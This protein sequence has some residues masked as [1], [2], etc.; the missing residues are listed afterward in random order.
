MTNKGVISGRLAL[1]LI[2]SAFAALNDRPIAFSL[3]EGPFGKLPFDGM[4]DFG[5]YGTFRD[6]YDAYLYLVPLEDEVFSPL[7]EGFYSEAFMPEIDRRCRLMDGKPL[8]ADANVPDP[9]RVTR[10][11]AA[12]WGQPRNWTS[13]LGPEDAW[14]YGDKW[15][16]HLVEVVNERH[17]AADRKELTAELDKVYRA[18]RELDPEQDSWQS[19]ERRFGFNYLTMTNWPAMFQW[20]S[21]ATRT[22]PL[23]SVTY[24]PL[25]HNDEGLPQIEVTVALEGEITFS[26][27]F[28]FKYLAEAERWQVQYGLDLHLDDDW[29]DLPEKDKAV[30][31]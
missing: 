22:H 4:P 26:K 7:I 23:E 29:K 11:R 19:W 6:G 27:I 31:L 16:E 2:D 21:D 1:G 15:R 3:Q 17:R 25:S 24:G 12:F 9:E 10:M 18:I 30:S 8:F 28:T 5:V 20:W 14:H 13:H